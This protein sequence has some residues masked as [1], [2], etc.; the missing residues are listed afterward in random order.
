MSASYILHFSLNNNPL[1]FTFGGENLYL[2]SRCPEF[3]VP[4][5]AEIVGCGLLRSASVVQ[6]MSIRV[7]LPWGFYEPFVLNL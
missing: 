1:F 7:Y 2:T 6:W 5:L 4:I 3:L